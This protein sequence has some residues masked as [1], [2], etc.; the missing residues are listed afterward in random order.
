VNNSYAH[1]KAIRQEKSWP[2]LLEMETWLRTGI[3]EELPESAIGIAFAYTLNL[4]PRLARIL[5]MVD[6]LSTITRSKT[7]SVLL[8]WAVKIISLPVHMKLRN[9][10][11]FYIHYPQA[12]KLTRSGHLPG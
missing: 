9:K 8:P 12:V 11:P 7:V 6:S 5:K 2:I 3:P 10:L 4:W 1:S